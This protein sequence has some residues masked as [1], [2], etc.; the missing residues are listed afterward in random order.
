MGTG[1]FRVTAPSAERHFIVA[2]G[3]ALA[4]RDA[5]VATFRR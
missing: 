5:F 2:P 3:A 4:D 1:A